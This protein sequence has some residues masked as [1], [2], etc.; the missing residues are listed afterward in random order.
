MRTNR[1]EALKSIQIQTSAPPGTVRAAANC[2]GDYIQ[3]PGIQIRGPV[4][5]SIMDA[6]DGKR[7]DR[8]LR[9]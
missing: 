8:A 9:A 4:K 6:F 7:E 5:S 2:A 3:N 1:R